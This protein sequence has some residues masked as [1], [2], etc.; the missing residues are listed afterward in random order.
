MPE[1]AH[2]QLDDIPTDLYERLAALAAREGQ[3][4]R[5]LV[6]DLV[7]RELAR[8]EFHSRLDTRQP[9]RLERLSAA[10]ALIAERKDSGRE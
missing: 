7:E 2:I 5:D 6:L 10:Q 9:V 3:T 8:R 1:M 4:I